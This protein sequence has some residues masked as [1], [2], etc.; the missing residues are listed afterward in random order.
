MEASLIGRRNVS[1][2]LLGTMNNLGAVVHKRWSS[3][4]ACGLRLHFSK[5]FSR[6]L[7]PTRVSEM[8]MKTLTFPSVLPE[9][10]NY[11]K[12]EKL[13]WGEWGSCGWF[14]IQFLLSHPGLLLASLQQ[15]AF[16]LM[17][18]L[19]RSRYSMKGF[20]QRAQAGTQ[21]R[22]VRNRACSVTCL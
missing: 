13:L 8:S 7:N 14:E 21:L 6:C 2:G 20:W 10:M 22:M 17:S 16:V 12:R 9:R 3:E 5:A 11:G 18:S 4:W 1:L 19:P 15:G